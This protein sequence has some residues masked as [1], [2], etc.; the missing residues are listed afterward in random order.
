MC[1]PTL[2]ILSL[3]LCSGWAIQGHQSEDFSVSAQ[4]AE[5]QQVLKDEKDV[6]PQQQQGRQRMWRRDRRAGRSK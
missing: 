6:S 3:L 4:A 1:G 2:T 5:L